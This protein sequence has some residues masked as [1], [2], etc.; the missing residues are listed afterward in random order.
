MILMCVEAHRAAFLVELFCRADSFDVRDADA[1]AFRIKGHRS[2]EPSNGDEAGEF[3]TT[4]A[5]INHPD[6]ILRAVGN[7][8]ALPAAIEAKRIRGGAEKISGTLL[9]PNRFDD[10]IG[11]R[12]DDGEVVARRI[13][14]HEVTCLR[15]EC[16]GRG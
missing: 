14:T 1:G 12:V 15:V 13:R 16:E 11:A 3:G 2:R 8:E 9:G 7:V 10:F 5:E 4:G 6:G